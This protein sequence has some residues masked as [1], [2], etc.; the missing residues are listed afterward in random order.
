M[1]LLYL[2]QMGSY[3]VNKFVYNYLF[4]CGKQ[5]KGREDPPG[6]GKD[7]RGERTEALHQSVYVGRQR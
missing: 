6:A 5:S 4:R 2:Y 3:I 1:Y 7:A